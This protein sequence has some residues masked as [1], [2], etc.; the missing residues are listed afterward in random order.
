MK[1]IWGEKTLGTWFNELFLGITFSDLVLTVKLYRS[2]RFPCQH[3]RERVCTCSTFSLDRE[4]KLLFRLVSRLDMWLMINYFT[5]AN[6][7]P[8]LTILDKAGKF[9]ESF[10]C[11]EFFFISFCFLEVSILFPDET[12]VSLRPCIESFSSFSFWKYR[13]SNL[14]AEC[15][16][17]QKCDRVVILNS[18]NSPNSRS[19]SEFN[20]E[21]T[22]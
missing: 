15:V 16:I 8:L 5:S 12:I 6:N 3:V 21:M 18:I 14:Q 4:G 17:L 9:C 13:P 1:L 11:V 19:G 20:L 2:L 10:F 22:S 7:F